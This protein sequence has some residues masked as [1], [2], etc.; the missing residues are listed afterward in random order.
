PDPFGW[1]AITQQLIVGKPREQ[2][3][4]RRSRSNFLDIFWSDDLLNRFADFDE[5]CCSCLWMSF[6]FAPFR[7][8]ICV[9]M[10]VDVA[11]QQTAFVTVNNQ[12]N[13]FRHAHRPEV[14]IARGIQFMKLHPRICWV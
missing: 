6:E 7:P 5:L 14:L 9:V 11:K 2:E 12:P 3:W 4:L 1:H 10:V 13:I 8:T